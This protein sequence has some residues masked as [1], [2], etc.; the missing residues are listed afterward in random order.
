MTIGHR[1]V[2]TLILIVLAAW[3]ALSMV[4][5]A[6]R[7]KIAREV[8]TFGIRIYQQE[9]NGHLYHVIEKHAWDCCKC[10]PTQVESV[11]IDGIQI[12]GQ[13]EKPKEGK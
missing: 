7:E 11:Q 12:D 13:A 2:V 3:S 5:A 9:I 1:L 6:R 8:A 10:E 4:L